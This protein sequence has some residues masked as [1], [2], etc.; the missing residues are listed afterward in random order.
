MEQMR[1]EAGLIE[2]AGDYRK[3]DR[4]TLSTAMNRHHAAVKDLGHAVSA[5][6][7]MGKEK[8]DVAAH[9]SMAA[10]SAASA[11]NIAAK[12][13]MLAATIL[14]EAESSWLKDQG[15]TESSRWNKAT[16]LLHKLKQFMGPMR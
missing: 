7:N 15:K 16:D 14:Y 1:G 11:V 9:Y 5:L 12:V 8:G 3:A 2:G 6:D 13:V 4:N 10:T